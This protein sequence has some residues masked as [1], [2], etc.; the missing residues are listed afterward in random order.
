MRLQ[1]WLGGALIVAATLLPLFA[2][3]A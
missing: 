1:D 3:R 2:R